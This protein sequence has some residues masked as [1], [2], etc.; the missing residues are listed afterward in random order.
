MQDKLST[1]TYQQWAAFSKEQLYKEKARVTLTLFEME[2]ARNGNG[3]FSQK[4]YL[5]FLF[6]DRCI[7]AFLYGPVPRQH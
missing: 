6:L 3:I 5:E 2:Q 4:Y 7:N 1:L